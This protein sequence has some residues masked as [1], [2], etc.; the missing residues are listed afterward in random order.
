[1]KQLLDVS[2]FE[3]GGGR[4]EPRTLRL[5]DLLG[6]LERAFHVLALQRDIEFRVQRRFGLPDEVFW[7]LDRINEVLGNLLSNAFKF[8]PHGGSVELTFEPVGA[9]V[10]MIVRDTG[11]GIPPEQLPRI[12]DKFYQADNQG[13]ARAAGTGLGTCHRE[14]NRRCSWRH[15]YVREHCRCRHD[16]H[17]Q[18][19]AAGTTTVVARLP[20]HSGVEFGVTQRAR[21]LALLTTV[22]VSM[23]TGCVTFHTPG[24]ATPAPRR[25]WPDALAT[26]KSEVIEGRFGSADSVLAEFASDYAGSDEALETAYWR[27][28]FRMDPANPGASLPAALASLDVYLARPPAAAAPRR[29]RRNPP[30]RRA[31][32]RSQQ[33]CGERRRRGEGREF[34]GGERAGTGRRRCRARRGEVR[35]RRNPPTRRSNA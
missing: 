24:F 32:R 20:R 11:A 6:E 27:A 8:T 16:V 30:C 1:M 5:D 22:L 12:F 26:A 15:D 28:I 33:A 34:D 9:G 35:R 2:R 23:N 19:A 21:A 14:A 10:A 13:A 31:T 7:D 3:A 17:D 4:L 29:G 18:D 25:N